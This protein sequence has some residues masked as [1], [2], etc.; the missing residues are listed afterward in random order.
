MAQRTL[1]GK[2]AQ[3]TACPQTGQAILAKTSLRFD[4]FNPQSRVLRSPLSDKGAEEVRSGAAGRLHGG[5]GGARLRGT[6]VGETMLE[7]VVEYQ[8]MYVYLQ[9]EPRQRE[10]KKQRPRTERWSKA[11][12]RPVIAVE[13]FARKSIT[14][15]KTFQLSVLLK[16]NT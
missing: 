9:Q 12:R 1:S 16:I 3:C 10:R 15:P 5:I 13:P 14:K 11:G 6:A 2:P 8:L 7:R 4:E